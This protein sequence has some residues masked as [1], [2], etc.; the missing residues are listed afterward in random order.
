MYNS[1]YR[2]IKAKEAKNFYEVF[3]YDKKDIKQ[4]NKFFDGFV[5]NY[6]KILESNM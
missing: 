6:L 5:D 1:F 4:R 3:D 2:G